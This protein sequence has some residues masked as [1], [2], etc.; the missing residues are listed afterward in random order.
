MEYKDGD[1]VTD[2]ISAG[3]WMNREKLLEFISDKLIPHYQNCVEEY[4]VLGEYRIIIHSACDRGVCFCS[5]AAFCNSLYS[6]YHIRLYG[7][8][9]TSYT[10]DC[11]SK[12]K[13]IE[14]LNFRINK[15]QELCTLLKAELDTD[16]Q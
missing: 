4:S 15:M 3:Y 1:I 8:C 7:S 6:N 10:R 16:N 9:W 14:L 2:E 11:F 12:E 5:S 13:N